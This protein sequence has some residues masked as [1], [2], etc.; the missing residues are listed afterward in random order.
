MSKKQKNVKKGKQQTNT[1]FD[2]FKKKPVVVEEPV[3]EMDNDSRNAISHSTSRASTSKN[4]EF[5]NIDDTANEQFP[6]YSSLDRTTV[7]ASEESNFDIYHKIR[8][9]VL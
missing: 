2:Y 3:E 5:V 1:L 9:N 8:N 6:V 7:R 4:V